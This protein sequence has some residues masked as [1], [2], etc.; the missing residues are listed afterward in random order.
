MPGGSGGKGAEIDPEEAF[1][2]SEEV[3]AHAPIIGRGRRG[4]RREFDVV[5]VGAGHAGTEAA[6]AAARMGARTAILTL[7]RESVG[8]MSC[9]PAIGG[10]AKGQLVREVDA[11]GGEMAKNTDETGIQ[12]RLLNT[13]KGLAVQSPRAQCDRQA[14]RE[15]MLRRVEREPNL[16]LIQGEVV[17]LLF[18]GKTV[19]GVRLESGLELRGR[20]TILTTGTFLRGLMHEGEKKADGGRLGD[21]AASWLS[22][23]LR[24]LGLELGRLKTGT[25]PRLDGGT[26]D[27]SVMRPQPGDAEPQPFSFST[28]KITQP[29][30][31]C[32][33][34]YTNERVHGA[35][36]A[37][38]HRAPMFNGQVQS[39]GPRYCPSIED[40]VHR[41]PEKT[42]HHV[43]LEP[44]GRETSEIYL[45]GV[46]TSLPRDVQEEIVHGI[47][48]LERARILKYG[49]AVEYDFVPPYQLAANMAA[50]GVEGLFLAGQING[51]S[52]YEEAAAQGIMAGINA[53]LWMR[54]EPP[55]LLRRH[56][57]YIGV[58]V[59]DL[60]V[61]NPTEP[62]RMFTSRAEYRL[63]LRHDNADRRL[64]PKAF[65]L[66]LVGKEAMDRLER[67]ERRIAL[68][69]GILGREF[70]EG[71]SLEQW[72]RRPGLSYTDLLPFS[73]A[74]REL[75]LI[76]D[77]VNQVEADV[78]YEGYIQRELIQVDRLR[79]EEETSIPEGIDY[80]GMMALRK[81]A[82]NQLAK[83]KPATVGAA[84]RVAG[85]T[86]ADLSLLAV[87]LSRFRREGTIRV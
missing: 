35:I 74:L 6:F 83:M 73:A 5:V 10:L 66:G 78:K 33:I 30:V 14:Y 24:A 17:A 22:E 25:P 46:S 31:P 67:K 39:V 43:F 80:G 84:S 70:R 8:Q 37:N 71:A 44:E 21:R 34:T 62:Y 56:E 58:L 59:D 68:A 1:A 77:E 36:R 63:L 32:W 79:R 27:F 69:R 48:G 18:E 38:L 2:I 3:L 20:A 16:E 13:R 85:V 9:N 57:A 50:K 19:L 42:S 41:F 55:F 52:G 26:V 11:L 60:V 75:A 86:P 28:E 4:L 76:P 49:Y 29:Q 51:T 65:R 61:A 54:G 82:R 45:N 87:Y 23:S 72:L 40:K 7:R 64:T 12:F 15:A 81:E 47:A 53:V